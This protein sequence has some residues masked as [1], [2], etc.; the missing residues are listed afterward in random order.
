[1]L[2]ANFRFQLV[3]FK[4]LETVKFL[5]VRLI[6]HHAMKMYGEVDIQLHAF[7]NWAVNGDE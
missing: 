7:L 4:K 1:V 2:L 6:K 5:S 3:T